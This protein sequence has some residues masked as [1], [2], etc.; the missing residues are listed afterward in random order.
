M[1]DELDLGCRPQEIPK[2]RRCNRPVVWFDELVIDLP[3]ERGTGD[4]DSVCI[5]GGAGFIGSHIADALASTADVRIYDD[6]SSGTT[7]QP[8]RKRA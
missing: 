5:S 8:P 2:H 3:F 7:E 4:F 1:I 6:L